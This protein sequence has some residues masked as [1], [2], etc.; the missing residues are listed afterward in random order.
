LTPQNFHPMAKPA[1]KY[2]AVQQYK[3]HFAS[4]S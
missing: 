3:I 2:A 1:K 4:S